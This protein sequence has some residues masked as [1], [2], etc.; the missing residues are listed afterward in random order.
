MATLWFKKDLQIESVRSF[1]DVNMGHFLGIQYLEL[2]PDYL[3]GS[4]PVTERV[5]QPLNILHGGASCVL[6][7][8]LASIAGNLVLDSAQQFA[9]GLEINANHL[10]SAK[11]GQ[12]VIGVSR[13]I[14]IGQSTHVWQTEIHLE[15]NRDALICIS[16][17]TLAIRDKKFPT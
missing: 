15:G 3:M 12:T 4:M 17:M 16:R 9:V 6:A 8:T 5:T 10:K 1:A 11:L 7:E 2:G 13:A 14:H